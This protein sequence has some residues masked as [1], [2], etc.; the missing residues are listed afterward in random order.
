MEFKSLREE[1]I[2]IYITFFS[3]FGMEGKFA[4]LQKSSETLQVC[5]KVYC[6]T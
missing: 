3:Q 5:K 6:V 4:I 1:E 2:Y